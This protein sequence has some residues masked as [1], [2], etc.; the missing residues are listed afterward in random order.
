M[1]ADGI[2]AMTLWKFLFLFGMVLSPFKLF[3]KP[4]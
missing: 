3:E 2:S 1:D 4:S